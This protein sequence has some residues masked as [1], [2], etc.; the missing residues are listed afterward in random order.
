MWE[1]LKFTKRFAWV[2]KT[3]VK[4]LYSYHC[5][6]QVNKT[7]VNEIKVNKIKVN[8]DLG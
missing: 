6:C 4:S 1:R 2:N 3:K 5:F 7:K 8:K